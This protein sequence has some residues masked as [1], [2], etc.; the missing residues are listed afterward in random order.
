MDPLTISSSINLLRS[1]ISLFSD[2]SGTASTIIGLINSNKPI[3]ESINNAIE[4]ALRTTGVK[5]DFLER[6]RRPLNSELLELVLMKSD[7]KDIT[8][9]TWFI[10]NEFDA[11]YDSLMQDMSVWPILQQM[12]LRNKV[13]RIDNKTDNVNNQLKEFNNQIDDAIRC[14]EK[15]I[16]KYETPKL[17]EWLRSYEK[18]LSVGVEKSFLDDASENLIREGK[19]HL[20]KFYIN[21]VKKCLDGKRV[22]LIKASEG[23]GKTYLSRIIAY[24]Y[25]SKGVEVYFLDLKDYNSLSVNSI[26]DKL[27]EWHYNTSN[28]LLILENVHAYNYSEALKEKINGWIKSKDNHI[29]FLLNTRPSYVELDEFSDWEEIVELNP[30]S[31]DINDIIDLYSKEVG[32]EP[33]KNIKEREEFVDN[34]YPV[35]KKASGANLRLLKIYLETWQNHPEIQYISRVKE[36]T[37]IERFRNKYLK[38]RPNEET[39]ALWYISSLF[40]FDVPVFED[41]MPDVGDLVKDGFLRFEKNRYHL[42]HSVDAFFL[43]KAICDIKHK[44]YIEQMKIFANR[45]VN[46][47]LLNCCPRDFESDFRLLN[48]GLIVRKDEFKEVILSLTKGDKAKEIILN[49]YPGFVF[50]LFRVEEYD[51][52]K[53]LIDYYKKNKDWIASSIREFNAAGLDKINLTFNRHLNYNT[54]IKDVFKNPDDLQK[55]LTRQF[56]IKNNDTSL[57]RILQ[58][59]IRKIIES[60]SP[61]HVAVL[62]K[63]RYRVELYKTKQYYFVSLKK[64][65]SEILI[66]S[67]LIHNEY[68]KY[69][70]IRFRKL[71]SD[72]H[73]QGFYVDKLTWRQLIVFLRKMVD[74][75]DE[76]YKNDFLEVTNN[77]VKII[78][79]EN[80]LFLIRSNALEKASST[81]LSLFLFYLERIDEILY[82][83]TISKA[84]II[85]TIRQKLNEVK[86]IT[87]NTL[88]LFSRFYSQEWCKTRMNKLIDEADEEQLSIIRKWHNKVWE[89]LQKERKPIEP[90]SLLIYVHNK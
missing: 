61:E 11:F 25:K 14:I 51:D 32:R 35:N 4:K 7:N 2:S 13:D 53:R 84:E 83:D 65:D 46:D 12:L 42:P 86:T 31:D 60:I 66:S 36:S 37:I 16:G 6:P 48:S 76:F 27:Q 47:I 38:D 54:I 15:I 45:F 57:S 44:N 70:E 63:F 21:K 10:G 50:A 5:K 39:K 19:L 17:P 59:E 22:C 69:D 71:V 82:K 26:D 33:F 52:S 77:L 80:N 64:M 23:R 72:L 88:Y 73:T 49:I 40:Q 79:D 28:Y 43:Y 56:E 89:G 62:E 78:I 75:I 90:D 67:Y 74:C 58:K 30:N 68:L 24:Y 1:G 18:E 87:T 20:N 3:S 85:K 8:I 81:Q 29:W 41:F 9:P 34:I 55:Y